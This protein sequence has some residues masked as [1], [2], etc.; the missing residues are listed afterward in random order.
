MMPLLIRDLWALVISVFVVMTTAA[1]AQTSPQII[2]P[3][4]GELFR[5]GGRVSVRLDGVSDTTATRIEY[6]VDG[7][8]TW[9]VVGTAI[10]KEI[11]WGVPDINSSQCLLRIVADEN[12]V[13]LSHVSKY[14]REAWF[15]YDDKYVLTTIGGIEGNVWNVA[16]K[17]R[18]LT[19][20][21]VSMMRPSPT[22]NSFVSCKG[23]AAILRSL[24]TGDTITALVGHTATITTLSFN[25]TGTRILTGSDDS[26]ARIWDASTGKLLYILSGNNGVVNRSRFSLDGRRILTHSRD[27]KVKVWSTENGELLRTLALYG[28]VYPSISPDGEHV[29]ITTFIQDSVIRMWSVATGEQV[30]EFGSPDTFLEYGWF[31]PTGSRIVGTTIYTCLYR[32]WDAKTG[33]F[34]RMLDHHTNSL[35]YFSYSPDNRYLVTVDTEGS[36]NIWDAESGEFIRSLIGYK[37]ISGRAAVTMA[38]F[39]SDSRY[40]ITS[41]NDGTARIWPVDGPSPHVVDVTDGAFTIWPRAISTSTISIDTTLVGRFRDITVTALLRNPDSADLPLSA[42]SINGLH[43]ANFSILSDP[44]PLTIPARGAYDLQLRFAPSI[45]GE[46]IATLTAVTGSGDTSR[47]ALSGIGRLQPLIS[48]AD[49]IDLGRVP[50]NRSRDTVVAV[51]ENVSDSI[52]VLDSLRFDHGDHFFRI[53]PNDTVGVPAHS[54]YNA[55]LTSTGRFGLT[56][57]D[58]LRIYHNGTPSPERVIIVAEGEIIAGVG[59]DHGAEALRLECSPN[60]AG[61][62]LTLRYETTKRGHVRVSVHDMQG[63]EVRVVADGDEPSGSHSVEV[64]VRSLAAGAY[65]GI[66]E[67]DGARV[68]QLVQV[69]R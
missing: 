25:A 33:S 42:L 41:G 56:V 24:S 5:S 52:V 30:R 23:S 18:N 35:A 55:T 60:P 68:Q 53:T 32:V 21:G 59:E 49:T 14:L 38:N 44:A 11:S 67:A 26:T 6:S 43:A 16:T 46:H 61:D 40:V 65:L 1:S 27:G 29:L 7:G 3:N 36:I 31:S 20:P 48:L 19:L 37:P 10:G 2:Y 8:V 22:D 69:V 45:I 47:I 15:S 66:V 64:D 51:L 4:G 34:L 9:D 63:R 12:A 57:A 28:N 17:Q 50:L 13:I 39:S 54:I 62:R 58:T